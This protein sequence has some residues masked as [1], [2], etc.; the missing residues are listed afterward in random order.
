[1]YNFTSLESYQYSEAISRNIYVDNL[2]NTFVSEQELLNFYVNAR[3]IM[4]TASFALRS[5]CSNSDDLINLT[6]NNFELVKNVEAV[7][8]CFWTKMVP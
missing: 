5:W 3:N 6:L 7:S 2:Q 8:K 4:N 1:M